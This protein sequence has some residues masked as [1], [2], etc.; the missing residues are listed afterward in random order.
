MDVHPSVRRRFSLRGQHARPPSSRGG[1]SVGGRFGVHCGQASRRASLLRGVRPCRRR[2][3]SGEAGPGMGPGE[4][5][6]S[7]RRRYGC[8]V[9]ASQEAFHV[10]RS[11]RDVGTPLRG[12]SITG[13]RAGCGISVR[14]C[15]ATR[16]PGDARSVGIAVRRCA[17]A[18]TGERVG[19]RVPREARCLESGLSGGCGMSARR[20]AATRSPGRVSRETSH[21]L[22]HRGTRGVWDLGTPLRGYSITGIGRWSSAARSAVYRDRH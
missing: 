2:I 22:D 20:C 19:G 6:R 5:P 21:V 12:Y 8:G 3:S 1:A 17:D 7:G 13:E 11:R 9:A 15:A 14:R 18:I 16:S 4:A 10:K